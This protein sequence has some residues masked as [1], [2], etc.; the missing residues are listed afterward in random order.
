MD[1]AVI[2]NTRDGETSSIWNQAKHTNDSYGHLY[3][4]FID[5]NFPCPVLS[6]NIGEGPCKNGKTKA[7]GGG[8]KARV[9]SPG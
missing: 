9:F 5:A 7:K 8:G 4:N 3:G 2:A 1:H 6:I